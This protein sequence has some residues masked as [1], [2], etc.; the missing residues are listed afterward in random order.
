MKMSGHLSLAGYV[1]DG[2]TSDSLGQ[3]NVVVLC[4]VRLLQPSMRT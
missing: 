1:S 3:G 4:G 2:W